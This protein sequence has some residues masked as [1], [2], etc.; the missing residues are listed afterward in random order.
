MFP[1]SFPLVPALVLVSISAFFSAS[2]TA[3]FSLSRFHLRELRQTAPERFQRIR[4]LLDRPA[5]LVATVLLGNELTNVLISNLLAGFYESWDLPPF[6]VTVLNLVTVL[7][8]IM[9]LGEITPKILAAKMPV[10]LSAFL[11]PPLWWFYKLSFPVRFL[12]ETTVNVITKPIRRRAGE[13]PEPQIKEDDLLHMLEEGKKKGAIH[14]VEQ[15]I[16]ENLFEIDDDSV[17]ELATPIQECFVVHQNDSPK[18]VI[19]RLGERFRARIPVRGDNPEEII[20][21]LY[22][23][24][25]LNYIN[26]DEQEMT[27]RNLMKEPL[28]VEPQMKVETLFRRFRQMKRHIAIIENK[29]GRALAVITMEDILE[30][31]FGE[32][33]EEHR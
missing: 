6:W 32:L 11:I 15:D 17:I 8:V 18:A 25:L 21:I 14:S 1:D 9:V 26:R 19:D 22:A 24:D 28:F 20:G 31:M 5:A 23:K 2:E 33:W 10:R 3:L 27:V 7:P 12:L 30:Q 13:R 4:H 29:A 16:I